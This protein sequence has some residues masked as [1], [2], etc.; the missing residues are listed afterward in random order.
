MFKPFDYYTMEK[1]KPSQ[2]TKDQ[3]IIEDYN[4]LD[5]N[6]LIRHVKIAEC[7]Y[8]SYHESLKNAKP[9]I[10]N[11]TKREQKLLFES[12]GLPQLSNI[13][14]NGK[15]FFLF[16]RRLPE[17]RVVDFI[18][19]ISEAPIAIPS[20]PKPKL[21]IRYR[22]DPQEIKTFKSKYSPS[23]FYIEHIK[24]IDETGTRNK[25]Q[26]RTDYLAL[27]PKEKLSYIKKTEEA[28]DKHTFTTV[29][30]EKPILSSILS[31]GEMK[32]LMNSYNIPNKPPHNMSA[33][34]FKMHVRDYTEDHM[35][36]VYAA[37]NKISE[38]EKEA[39]NIEYQKAADE[40]KIKN[41][42]FLEKLPKQ[43]IPDAECLHTKGKPK[44][45]SAESEEETEENQLLPDEEKLNGFSQTLAELDERVAKE[46]QKTKINA[47]ISEHFN[48]SVNSFSSFVAEDLKSHSK[49]NNEES[50]DY[51]RKMAT[52]WQKLGEKGQEEYENLHKKQKKELKK[53]IKKFLSENSDLDFNAEEI[54]EMIKQQSRSI[55]V[56]FEDDTEEDLY[57]GEK[58]L[59]SL[60]DQAI[61]VFETRIKKPKAVAGTSK[62]LKRKADKELTSPKKKLA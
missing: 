23:E 57:L 45:T 62:S 33:Y 27:E 17:K 13:H 34:Y 56:K 47:F 1:T 44:K 58:S 40:Y 6:V 31:L 4:K 26:L 32:L 8:D 11:L 42:Q 53:S 51:L 20:P 18:D 55:T 7:A 3:K 41:A 25:L 16:S 12:Y 24:K 35:K 9:F 5:D 21:T 10:K 60:I 61:S 59:T 48:H 46:K 54:K 52:K 15:D 30:D 29:D 39:L 2:D 36:N 37:Y 43:R 14:E 50:N 28:F 19:Y 49:M 22:G 38:S